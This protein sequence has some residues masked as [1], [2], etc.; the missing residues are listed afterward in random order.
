M[1]VKSAQM[2]DLVCFHYQSVVK[3]RC[4]LQWNTTS[5]RHHCVLKEM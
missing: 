5:E 4:E 1:F 3:I 2:E